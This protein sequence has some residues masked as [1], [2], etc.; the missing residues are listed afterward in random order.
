MT[1][2]PALLQLYSSSTVAITTVYWLSKFTTLWQ[3]KVEYPRIDLLTE[4]FSFS[5][6]NRQGKTI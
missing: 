5:P 1:Y 4:L 2:T 6:M 3:K